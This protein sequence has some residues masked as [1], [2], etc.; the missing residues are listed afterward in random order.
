MVGMSQNQ[1]AEQRSRTAR[2][3]GS[4]PGWCRWPLSSWWCGAW[5]GAPASWRAP[6]RRGNCASLRLLLTR[7]LPSRVAAAAADAA[8]A[9]AR[10]FGCIRDGLL[11]MMAPANGPGRAGPGKRRHVAER[12]GRLPYMR[13]SAGVCGRRVRASLRRTRAEAGAA[14][15]RV[16]AGVPPRAC[17]SGVLGRPSLRRGQRPAMLDA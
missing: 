2:H 13:S 14:T 3:R 7:L 16:C 5:C 9:T 10:R 15:A 6:A 1:P 17:G 8:A 4:H 11:I 12:Q